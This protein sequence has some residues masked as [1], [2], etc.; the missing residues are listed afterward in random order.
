MLQSGAPA[1]QAGRSARGRAAACCRRARDVTTVEVRTPSPTPHLLVALGR[2]DR[3]DC[4]ARAA[5][6][7]AGAG[8]QRINCSRSAS[9]GAWC[10]V[11]VE[12]GAGK[13]GRQLAL[14]GLP[15][16]W[17]ATPAP[18]AGQACLKRHHPAAAEVK[19]RAGN[20]LRTTRVSPTMRLRRRSEADGHRVCSGPTC[21]L[22]VLTHVGFSWVLLLAACKR[23]QH[24]DARGGQSLGGRRWRGAGGGLV[25]LCG[26]YGA[27]RRGGLNRSSTS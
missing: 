12:A 3:R 20:S 6:G 16:G 2:Y 13:G 5:A 22:Q 14:A 15:T 27:R 21:A 18:S 9:V 11:E 24:P 7:G 4:K 17:Y 26:G 23:L 19:A 8:L 25:T 1:G 10:M